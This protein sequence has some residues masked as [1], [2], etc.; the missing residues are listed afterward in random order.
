MEVFLCCYPAFRLSVVPTWVRPWP[1]EEAG[2]SVL[3]SWGRCH[4]A[5]VSASA[6]SPCNSG[7]KGYTSCLWLEWGA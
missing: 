6:G 5:Q 4:L 1:G 3:S 2:S 7:K